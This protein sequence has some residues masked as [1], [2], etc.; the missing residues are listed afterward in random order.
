[1]LLHTKVRGGVGDGG[2]DDDDDDNNKGKKKNRDARTIELWPTH[3]S[4]LQY[5]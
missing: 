4:K 5:Y 3:S 2:G 1:M